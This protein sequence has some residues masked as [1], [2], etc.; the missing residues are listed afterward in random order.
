M[1]AKTKAPPRP[2]RPRGQAARLRAFF[3]DPDPGDAVM[4]DIITPGGQRYLDSI[5][6]N[7]TR[8]GSEKIHPLRFVFPQSAEQSIGVSR[9]FGA[10]LGKLIPELQGPDVPAPIK[11]R[12]ASLPEQSQRAIISIADALGIPDLPA[13]YARAADSINNLAITPGAPL[14]SDFRNIIKDNRAGEALQ[15]YSPTEISDARAQLTAGAGP[16]APEPSEDD[17]LTQL[18]TADEEDLDKSGI[19]FPT[20][21]PA[22]FAFDSLDTT[23]EGA[24]PY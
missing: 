20:Y 4:P 17:L 5:T 14:P 11:R 16:D 6:P 1:P 22:E 19:Y 10:N 13:Y 2:P 9:P 18:E 7:P 3:N 8:Q 23:Q 15:Y 24:S 21:T 12:L